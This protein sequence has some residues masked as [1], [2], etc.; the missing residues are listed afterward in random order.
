ML[1]KKLDFMPF[2]TSFFFLSLIF[3]KV[4]HFLFYC[5]RKFAPPKRGGGNAPVSP[6]H[7]YGRFY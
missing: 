1:V 2:F 5:L 7:S 3:L 6:P 4:F